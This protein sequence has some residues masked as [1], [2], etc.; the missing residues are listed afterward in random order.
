MISE[1]TLPD[2]V[3][4]IGEYAFSY[5]LPTVIL[6]SDL[7]VIGNNAF[8]NYANKSIYLP[9]D[10]TYIGD[11]AF[12]GS[13]L[14][15]ITIPGNVTYIGNDAFSDI[16]S[17]EEAYLTYDEDQVNLLSSSAIQ[18]S[19]FGKDDSIK[20]VLD[21]GIKSTFDKKFPSLSSKTVASLEMTGLKN[22][23][24][25]STT[26]SIKVKTNRDDENV[27][28]V[29]T[30]PS[31]AT[32][33][34][35]GVVSILGSGKFSIEAKIDG[36]DKSYD[37]AYF[38][39]ITI[40]NDN[41]CGEFM[42]YSLLEDNTVLEISG[43]GDMDDYSYSDDPD[44]SNPPPWEQYKDTI[45]KVVFKP[46]G[47]KIN[48]IGTFAFAGISKL[49]DVKMD[50]T[51]TVVGESA[52][53]NCT[54]LTSVKIPD[55]TKTIEP[56]TFSGCTSLKT[57]EIPDKV[58]TVGNSSFKNCTNLVTVDFLDPINAAS[59]DS[60][61]IDESAFEN[62]KS[63]VTINCPKTTETIGAY[64]FKGCSSLSEFTMLN[65][66]SI[67]T[68]AFENCSS[69]STVN[70]PKTTSIIDSFAFKGCI[71]LSKVEFAD[72]SVLSTIN[73]SAF[74]NCKN[75]GSI[76]IPNTVFT[77]GVASFKDCENLSEATL[78]LTI[79]SIPEGTFE[80]CSSL[81]KISLPSSV[82]SIG[83]YSFKNC[84]SLSTVELSVQISQIGD[85]SFENCTSLGTIS[86]PDTVGTLGSS[87]F[88][89]CTSLS[90]ANIPNLITSI[91]A[92]T[93][94][95]CTSL[96]DILI[97]SNVVTIEELSFSRCT[98]L[99]SISLP[100]GVKTIKTSAFAGCDALDVVNMDH[101][102]NEIDG[103]S[104]DSTAFTENVM[105]V[106]NDDYT[107][108]AFNT[109]FDG[110]YRAV[111]QMKI[112]GLYRASAYVNIPNS[113]LLSYISGGQDEFGVVFEI[114]NTQLAQINGNGDLEP[115]HVGDIVITAYRDLGDDKEIK[116]YNTCSIS[117]KII[118]GNITG[119]SKPFDDITGIA[120]GA[121]KSVEGLNLPTYADVVIG[122]TGL[123]SVE[124]NWDVS[125]FEYDPTILESQTFTVT[126]T[127]QETDDIKN[128]NYITVPIS[129]TV[130][131]KPP[132]PEPAPDINPEPEPEPEPKSESELES[133][134]VPA[135]V[136]ESSVEPSESSA[137]S[138]ESVSSSEVV[139]DYT[140]Y[141]E[142]EITGEGVQ[143]TLIIVA[144]ICALSVVTIILLKKKK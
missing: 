50:D 128:P 16:D 65:I 57:V 139:S 61:I 110:V 1:I 86:M 67:Y 111:C 85:S 98:S 92:S 12:S 74:E 31:V 115:Q 108:D 3:E 9:E 95:N 80:N 127:L 10:L 70:I 18:S 38:G 123:A 7:S 53:E 114:D 103:L 17:L 138:V 89:G 126:G 33:D 125:T 116:S 43:S 56:N 68:S 142:L 28:F 25:K 119:L 101:S 105:F 41:G 60:K 26:K 4:K 30:S 100:V 54:S 135:V 8:S 113:D 106:V 143:V 69:L 102:Q 73:E 64:A 104:I 13:K 133:S 44:E 118:P 52:F 11:N 34:D 37:T 109:K 45:T 90:T 71:S 130:D 93:F 55:M 112:S 83:N 79:S 47:D 49:N 97:P 131:A 40:E 24:S 19:S 66:V 91:P 20:L 75:L 5:S 140:S 134:S 27:K 36:S 141:A 42:T 59:T 72:E 96:I 62:C 122:E 23:Y 63:L 99:T 76:S 14:E 15:T 6:P 32:I 78:P 35:N 117:V 51:I 121:E 29:S 39:P 120:N 136:S 2:S 88:K 132:E 144:A 94:E 22:Q 84:A 137:V 82:T 48:K 58:I 81:E 21:D 124:I 87:V 107:K 77:L 129:V 46:E